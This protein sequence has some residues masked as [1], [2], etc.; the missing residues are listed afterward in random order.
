MA[1]VRREVIER[2][3]ELIKCKTY[4]LALPLAA[5]NPGDLIRGTELDDQLSCTESFSARQDHIESSE[6]RAETGLLRLR[7]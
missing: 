6:R 4:V 7:S 5:S 3:N 2:P 1:K